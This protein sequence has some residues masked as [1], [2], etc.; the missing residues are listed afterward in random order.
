MKRT[1][2][3]AA[4]ALL[5][6]SGAALASPYVGFNLNANLLDMNQANA[7]SFPQTTLGPDFHA[8]YRFDNLNLAGELGYGISRGDQTPDNLRINMLTADALYYVPIGGFL[9]VVLT[10]GMAEV[11]YGDSQAT[12][13]VVQENGQT[14]SVRTG[15]TIFGGNELDW[16][17]GTGLS[18]AFTD[19]YEVHLLTRYQPLSMGDRT[20]YSLSAGFG[21]NFYF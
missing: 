11:N 20:N 12:F 15:N 1:L 2:I 18:F 7:S 8:G 10:A 4:I 14:K 9:N 21:M 16:R 6:P 19:G 13:S 17:V 3:A 5:L